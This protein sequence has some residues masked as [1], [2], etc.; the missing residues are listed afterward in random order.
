MHPSLSLPPLN[1][2]RPPHPSHPCPLP[3]LSPFPAQG[4]FK[5][6]VEADALCMGQEFVKSGNL[7][8][9]VADMVLTAASKVFSS[10][11]HVDIYATLPYFMNPVLAAC[12]VGAAAVCRLHV[13]ATC[14]LPCWAL[15]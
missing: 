14:C 2:L 13:D 5:R 1:V 6:E 12:Q 7:P 9:W 11:T 3:C 8:N 10:S 15:V 4:K